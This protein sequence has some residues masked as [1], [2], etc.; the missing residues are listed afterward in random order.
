MWTVFPAA[1]LL[2]MLHLPW[3]PPRIEF[4]VYT[5]TDFASKFMLDHRLGTGTVFK[6]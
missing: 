3:F 4:M 5:V 6:P 1:S 2:G